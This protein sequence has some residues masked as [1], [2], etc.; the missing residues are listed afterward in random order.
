MSHTERVLHSRRKRN[1]YVGQLRSACRNTYQEAVAAVKPSDR[2]DVKS[3]WWL[4]RGLVAVWVSHTQSRA[5]LLALMRPYA[6]IYRW[7]NFYSVIY[8]L[9]C[10]NA[11]KGALSGIHCTLALEHSH[12]NMSHKIPHTSFNDIY[13]FIRFY[14][15]CVQHIFHRWRHPFSPAFLSYLH[16]SFQLHPSFVNWRTVNGE[17]CCEWVP[18]GMMTV[19]AEEMEVTGIFSRSGSKAVKGELH[20]KDP[21]V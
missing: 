10:K 2:L 4:M 14:S 21:R 12:I 20:K 18:W 8:N 9:L 1:L 15:S 6:H 11:G 16:Q 7:N 17:T 3:E 19:I 13:I 5:H